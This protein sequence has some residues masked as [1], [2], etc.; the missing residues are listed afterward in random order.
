MF[1]VVTF[2]FVLC[3]LAYEIKYVAIKNAKLAEMP[4]G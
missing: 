4:I 3:L 2:S 1:V